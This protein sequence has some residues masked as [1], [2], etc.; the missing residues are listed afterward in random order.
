MA[1]VRTTRRAAWVTTGPL[2]S[3]QTRRDSRGRRTR[4][5][6]VPFAAIDIAKNEVGDAFTPANQSGQRWH[7]ERR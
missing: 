2:A 5:A 1:M 6:P 4:G 7:R 3:G